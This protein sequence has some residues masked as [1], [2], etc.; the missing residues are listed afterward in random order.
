MQQT[1]RMSTNVNTSGILNKSYNVPTIPSRFLTPV[2]NFDQGDQNDSIES[3]L[4]SKVQRLTTDGTTIGPGQY[5]VV[6]SIKAVGNSP[7]GAIKWS[8]SKSTRQDHFTK[9]YTSVDVGPGKYTAKNIDRQIHN[10]TIPRAME[11]K[12]SPN[13]S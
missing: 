5:N 1:S 9:T 11:Q 6:K 12:R 13:T 7:R 2:L 3:M 10:P 4:I 8:N